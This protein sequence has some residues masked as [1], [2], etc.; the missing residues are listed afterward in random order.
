[1]F[2]YFCHLSA[3]FHILFTTVDL[4]R[5]STVY[6]YIG[7]YLQRESTVLGLGS[8]HKGVPYI[9]VVLVRGGSAGLYRHDKATAGIYALTVYTQ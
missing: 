6:T 3:H 4:Q 7:Q 5:E 9:T 8:A 1:M 2:K